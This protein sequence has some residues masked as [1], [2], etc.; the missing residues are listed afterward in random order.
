[1]TL[2]FNQDDLSALAEEL[3]EKNPD[4]SEAIFLNWMVYSNTQDTERL[5]MEHD[6]NLINAGYGLM[7]GPI[8]VYEK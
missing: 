3:Q 6:G 4:S 1:L 7:D 5:I 2:T 8:F